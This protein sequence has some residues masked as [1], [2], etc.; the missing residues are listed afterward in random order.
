MVRVLQAKQLKSNP[1]NEGG[2]GI[3]SL[4][5][6]HRRFRHHK[7]TMSPAS[8]GHLTP[9][10]YYSNQQQQLYANLSYRDQSQLTTMAL[11]HANGDYHWSRGDQSYFDVTCPSFPLRMGQQNIQQ[12]VSKAKQTSTAAPTPPH[13][14]DDVSCVKHKRKIQQPKSNRRPPP[15]VLQLSLYSKSSGTGTS[16]KPNKLHPFR[17]TD[18]ISEKNDD[19]LLG[20]CSIN[21]LRILSGKTPYFDEWCTLHNDDPQINSD[22]AAG[23]VRIVIE[24]EPTD[25]P[26]R[27][28][29]MCVFANVYPLMKELYPIPLHSI[30]NS[31]DGSVRSSTSMSTLSSTTS[32]I[33]TPHSS[34]HTTASSL[35]C[36]PKTYR[37]EEVVGSDHV[38]LSYQTPVENWQCTF[39]VHRYLLLC[40]ERHQAAV[41][42]YRERVLDLCDN[43][44][45]SPMVGTLTKTVETLPDEGLVYAGAELVG[46]GVGLLGRWWEN[47]VEGMVEDVVDGIN[48]DGRYSHLLGEEEKEG[49][50]AVQNSSLQDQSQQKNSIG[51]TEAADTQDSRR[52][53]PGMPCCPITGLPMVE[54]VVASDGHTYERYAIARWLQTSNRSPLTGEVLAH[55]E[56]VPNY[57]L[58][59]S[60][61]N[62][63]AGQK[64]MG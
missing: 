34:S 49:G 10:S 48:L 40:V 50:A 59:S 46:G 6:K 35:T 57:L 7:S 24:Y 36:H 42:K 12:R 15:P 5:S 56:L 19:Y 16:H 45:L 44:S 25:P 39:E 53:M 21:I 23:R 30:R 58:L 20:K 18:N 27:P 43:L 29:D 47:G 54:P 31:T 9:S 61:G 4:L 1:H 14:K 3:T 2:G 38:V 26:P 17:N 41:E 55:P 22:E 60:L 37:V 52:A 63:E 32:S 13:E 64:E 11:E 28:G 51:M 8:G 33:T 62:D